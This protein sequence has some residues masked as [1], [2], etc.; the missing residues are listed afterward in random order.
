M[1]FRVVAAHAKHV[2]GQVGAAAPS[3][4]DGRRWTGARTER[5]ETDTHFFKMPMKMRSLELSL[6]F[7]SAGG[8]I[9][10]G[11]SDADILGDRGWARQRHKGAEA[12]LARTSRLL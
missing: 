3:D 10:G 12:R 5:C 6:W 11:A 8:A 1:V 9:V 7:S 2:M 4:V